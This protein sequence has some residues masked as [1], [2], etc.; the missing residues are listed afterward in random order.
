MTRTFRPLITPIPRTSGR[1]NS[2][3]KH[4][5]SR[6][7][8]LLFLFFSFQG[9]PFGAQSLPDVVASRIN[10]TRMADQ[11]A[12]AT[13]SAKIAAAIADLPSTGGIVDATG[14]SGEQSLT[15]CPFVGVTKPTT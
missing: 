3:M 6:L 14:L 9:V 15:T 4:S 8:A 12:G 7:I 13:A 1:Y 5:F 2:S 11:F 10:G